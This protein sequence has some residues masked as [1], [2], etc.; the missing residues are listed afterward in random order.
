MTAPDP[1]AGW[2][3]WFLSARGG[4]P[5][6]EWGHMGQERFVDNT[7][8]A[9]DDFEE[10]RTETELIDQ[11]YAGIGGDAVPAELRGELAALKQRLGQV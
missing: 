1:L 10:W 2:L 7:G 4:Q 5:W 6:V 9:F 11:W 3:P 8:A